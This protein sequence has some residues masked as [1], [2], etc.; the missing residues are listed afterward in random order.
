MYIT[1]FIVHT[2]EC[3]QNKYS[4]LRPHQPKE[5]SQ[6]RAPRSYR[7]NIRCYHR[8]AL[9][10]S[11]FVC[12]LSDSLMNIHSKRE[13]TKNL[14]EEGRKNRQPVLFQIQMI[15]FG[16]L[17]LL[18]LLESGNGCFFYCT[19]EPCFSRSYAINQHAYSFNSWFIAREIDDERNRNYFSSCRA[20]KFPI[21]FFLLLLI[22][23]FLDRLQLPNGKPNEIYSVFFSP[24]PR[25]CLQSKVREF[26]VNIKRTF[27]SQKW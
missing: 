1:C 10:N 3:T 13:E 16:F 18:P 17:F 27:Y 11:E 12:L 24:L 23:W 7:F 8:P 2:C 5:R 21:A 4:F 20:Y 22:L 15:C 26:C 9:I 25:L 14:K 6:T 19:R